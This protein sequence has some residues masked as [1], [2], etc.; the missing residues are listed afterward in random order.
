MPKWKPSFPRTSLPIA[1]VL[2][3]R[4]AAAINA[5]LHA[6]DGGRARRC[7][8]CNKLSHLSGLIWPADRDTP[9]YCI[10]LTRAVAVSCGL[11]GEPL[12][13]GHI[14]DDVD[15]AKLFD[16]RSTT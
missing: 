7:E 10:K 13:K 16:D 4:Y 15:A 6:R 9:I 8:E 3:Y 1:D 12:D 14:R 2:S 5:V 11:L